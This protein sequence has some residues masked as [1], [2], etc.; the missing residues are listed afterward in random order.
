MK[1]E[2]LNFEINGKSFHW[3]E[4]YITGAELR[5]LGN[6]PLDEEIFLSIKKPWEDELITDEV[7]VNLARPEIENFFFKDKHF[8]VSLIVNLKDKA[9]AE[10]KINFKD[11]IELA[12]NTYDP[13]PNKGY[14]VTY[15]RGPRQNP[16]GSMVAGDR[17]FVKDKMI[18]NVKQTDKS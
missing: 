8:K 3:S 13:N 18:F 10:K 15:D 16:E 4:Q 2:T 12:Y 6:V 7:K 17:V 9:W 1:T 11:V 14:T 5:K